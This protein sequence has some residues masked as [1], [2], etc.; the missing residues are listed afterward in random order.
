MRFRAISGTAC[1]VRTC[2]P[3]EADPAD[4]YRKRTDLE[5]NFLLSNKKSAGRTLLIVIAV[6][7]PFL[8]PALFMLISG[9]SIFDTVPYYVGGDAVARYD[10]VRNILEH[11]TLLGYNGYDFVTAKIPSLGS[12][13]GFFW[14]IPYL[15]F[16]KVL[17]WGLNAP[18][19]ANILFLCLANLIFILLTKCSNKAVSLVILA[20]CLLYINIDYSIS[21]MSEP[22]RYAAAI[23]LAG[24]M[25]RLAMFDTSCV[26]RYVIVPLFIIYGAAI[27]ILLAAF[28]IPYCIIVIRTKSQVLKYGITLAVF[29]AGTL[30]IKR[31]NSQFCTPYFQG[32][33]MKKDIAALKEG[34]IPGI[35]MIISTSWKNFY[36][37]SFRAL[38]D[39]H[40]QHG[41]YAW[42]V[43]TCWS[44]MLVLALLLILKKYKSDKDKF[45]LLGAL[46]I[47][48]IIT[49]GYIVLYND[50]RTT[51][52]R[53]INTALCTAVFL[54]TLMDSKKAVTYY[55][56]VALLFSPFFARNFISMCNDD[57]R[58]LNDE[59]RQE[60]Q[61][62][63][64]IAAKYIT[65]E[66]GADPWEN[67]VAM[68]FGGRC[69]AFV[70]PSGAGKVSMHKVHLN[71][72]ARYV[73]AGT[74]GD[75]DEIA[76]FI[77]DH[78]EHGH[79]ILVETDDFTILKRK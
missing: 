57:Y 71:E 65:L 36:S 56:V 45:L 11:G 30:F 6:I 12:A 50:D 4:T 7:T 61:E 79:E 72:K 14:A 44:L 64:D 47:L 31:A 15:I 48:L 19:M 53:G 13:W 32:F 38:T 24:M 76:D 49:G 39:L 25:Y 34:L 43:F 21:G 55:I 1:M 26:F 27:F 41:Q 63:R 20:S 37:F 78:V 77:A 17:G 66:E 33:N 9:H 16:G 22:S 73:L 68:R 59:Q 35:K 60:L 23:I 74:D 62:R 69:T 2:A 42:F 46:Y 51:M 58:C 5:Q 54:T 75:E 18:I 52:T 28:I 67:T 3:A 29:L 8:V 40:Y 10:Y 70:V